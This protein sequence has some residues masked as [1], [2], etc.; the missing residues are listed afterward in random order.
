MANNISEFIRQTAPNNNE[1]EAKRYE[2]IKV[3]M[4]AIYN[5]KKEEQAP[6]GYKINWKNV[7]TIRDVIDILRA[8]DLSIT[9]EKADAYSAV[10]RLI[11]GK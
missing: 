3:D 10:K 7:A 5:N 4:D 1:K 2:N 11:I 8:L 6:A 9:P